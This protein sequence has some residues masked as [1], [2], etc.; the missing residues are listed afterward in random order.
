MNLLLYVFEAVILKF[1]ATDFIL[2]LTVF[3]FYCLIG[4]AENVMLIKEDL[5]HMCPSPP[6]TQRA[7]VQ[8]Q[9]DQSAGAQDTIILKSVGT[10]YLNNE[11][12]PRSPAPPSQCCV[13][14]RRKFCSQVCLDFETNIELG[15][16]GEPV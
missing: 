6:R 14:N 9:R 8:G 3:E 1:T 7:L 15:E 12:K 13:Q 4:T 2:P 16:G 11:H 5:I 10:G